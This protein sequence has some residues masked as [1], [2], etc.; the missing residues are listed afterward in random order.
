MW[1]STLGLLI[2]LA[3]LVA[4]IKGADWLVDGAAAIA[5]RYEVSEL[6]LGLSLIAL[7]TTLPELVVNLIASQQQE[8]ELV[9]SNI[10]GSIIIN[11]FC[12]LGLV[13][14]MTPLYVRPLTIKRDIP[15]A[16]FVIGVV[17]VLLNDRLFFDAR[18]NA[19]DR[20]DGLILL[21][22]L[23]TYL[24]SIVRRL[25]RKHLDY[26]KPEKSLSKGK[27][28][29]YLIAGGIALAG[30]GELTVLAAQELTEA[31]QVSKKLIGLTILAP[32]TAFPELAV[33]F[34]AV[35]KKR[36][37]IAVGNIIGANI[38]NVVL[39]LSVSTISGP[40][41]YNYKLNFDWLFAG[42]GTAFL[43]VAMFTG[44]ARRLDRWEAGILFGFFVA[45]SFFLF[46]RL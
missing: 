23:F 3:G 43:F 27:Q 34:L 30:G 33:S 29:W 25:K 8:Y 42:L 15:F 12:V 7:S 13:G 14:L 18:D 44:K 24:V 32:G 11:I 40:L 38:L 9:F 41:L 22:L 5:E 45:Y 19:L 10:V 26:E 37:D 1:A 36:Y 28:W 31:W 4:L 46:I 2:L 21:G 17:F 20:F 16:V 6:A 35:F 39:V